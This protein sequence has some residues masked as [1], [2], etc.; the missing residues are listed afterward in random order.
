MGLC[1]VSSVS[2]FEYSLCRLWVSG[3]PGQGSSDFEVSK[4][5]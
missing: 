2:G 3:L 1:R 5:L 4:G